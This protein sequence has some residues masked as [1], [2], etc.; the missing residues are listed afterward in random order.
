MSK[1]NWKWAFERQ[2]L[3][4]KIWGRLLYDSDTPDEVF[5][6][7]FIRRYGKDGENLLKAS[8][9]AG[10]TPL[11]FASNTDCGWDFTL[12]SEAIDGSCS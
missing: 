11:V 8:S 7:E 6:A 5:H 10:I 2:W 1:A 12:Y 4:Y 3:Y 9:L